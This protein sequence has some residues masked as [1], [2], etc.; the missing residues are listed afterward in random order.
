MKEENLTIVKEASAAFSHNN[1]PR[2]LEKLAEDVDWMIAG[3]QSIL[4]YAGEHHGRQQVAASVAAWHQAEEI[5]A[6]EPKNFISD[7][8]VVI[9]LGTYRAIIKSTRRLLNIQWAHV[10]TIRGGKIIRFRGFFDTFAA[11]ESYTR[12]VMRAAAGSGRAWG[13]PRLL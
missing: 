9:V 10:Y 3:P 2:L 13:T 7:G 12:P 8:D 1:I 6:F 4:P 5:E 11:S